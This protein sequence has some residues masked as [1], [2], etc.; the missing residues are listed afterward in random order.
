MRGGLLFFLCGLGLIS[1]GTI[2]RYM[3]SH[4]LR[5]DDPLS[6]TMRST[7]LPDQ[8]DSLKNAQLSIDE[9][10]PKTVDA[11]DDTANNG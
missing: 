7:T 5:G 4:S 3:D 2:T 8:T 1:I 9:V 11:W 10:L 6:S